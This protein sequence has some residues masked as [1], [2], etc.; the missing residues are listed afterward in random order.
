MV[1]AI[2]PSPFERPSVPPREPEDQPTQTVNTMSRP[3]PLSD[4]FFFRSLM[5]TTSDSIYFKDL[6]CRLL[7]VS[8]KMAE[9]FGCADPA[10]LAGKTDVDLFGEEFGQRTMQDDLRVMQLDEPLIGQTESRQ[11][12]S[13]LVNWTLT[14]KFPL[15]DA[16]GHVV[17]LMGITREINEIKQTEI[18]LQGIATHD[19]LTGLPNRYLALDRLN[20][21]LVR[22]DRQATIFAILFVDIDGFKAINDSHGHAVGD[23]VL[24]AVADTLLG[25][26]RA[27]DTVARIGG[28]EFVILLEG[29]RAGGDATRVAQKIRRAFG[30]PLSLPGGDLEVTVSIGIGLYPEDG[31]DADLLLNVADH[32]MY[33]AKREDADPRPPDPDGASGTP[34][35]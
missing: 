14:T 8:R 12:E 26:V 31:R 24:R 4:D 15:H 21:L 1:A 18:A 9:E 25:N 32:A 17:G 10:E 19:T 23:L 16:E 28:D 30:K 22:A 3:D 29:L 20:Q 33:L 35:G 13:G 6:Q 11:L 7:R 34:A 2:L 27:G 5:A